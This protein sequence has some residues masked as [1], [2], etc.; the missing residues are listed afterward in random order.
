MPLET[1]IQ[2]FKEHVEEWLVHHK[3]KFALVV[4]NELVAVFD[5]SKSAYEFGVQK[6]GNIPMLIKQIRKED[7]IAYFPALTLGLINARS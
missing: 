3:D 4:G 2:F 7:E 6:Y 5:T 1:E